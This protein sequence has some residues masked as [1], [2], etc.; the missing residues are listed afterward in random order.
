MFIYHH[1][2]AKLWCNFFG[3]QLTI[4]SFG[5]LS[6]PCRSRPDQTALSSA[7]QNPTPWKSIWDELKDHPQAVEA[8][9][10]SPVESWL[11]ALMSLKNIG[12]F[13]RSLGILISFWWS[14]EEGLKVFQRYRANKSQLWRPVSHRHKRPR[15]HVAMKMLI[16]TSPCGPHHEVTNSY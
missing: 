2:N 5:P 9:K 16:F 3:M 13:W 11:S 7:S 12:K 15:R 1:L 10:S 6:V 4:F 8:P 14:S